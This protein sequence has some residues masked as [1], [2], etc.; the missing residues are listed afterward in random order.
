[1]QN[2]ALMI[3]QDL[4]KAMMERKKY[5][6][7]NHLS[8]LKAGLYSA[9]KDAIYSNLTTTDISFHLQ[10]YKQEGHEYHIAK[11]NE[12]IFNISF[13]IIENSKG[14]EDKIKLIVK[15]ILTILTLAIAIGCVGL[16]LSKLIISPIKIRMDKLNNFI[17][18]SAHELNTPISALMMSVSSIKSSGTISKK[19]LNHIS[20]STKLISEIYNTLSFHAFHERDAV[21]D[22]E[23]DISILIQESVSF[24]DEIAISKN[25]HFT[26]KLESTIIKMDKSRAKKITNNLLSNA[27][28]YGYK[29]SEISILLENRTLS[30]TNHGKGISSKNKDE[31]FQ[32]YKR[33]STEAGGFGIGLNI[34]KNI[35]D[36]YKIKIECHST[37]K[38]RTTFTLVFPTS[39][40]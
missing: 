38:E 37:P 10:S 15:I 4:M 26:C 6:F 22:E 11:L 21:L 28:K 40:S 33:A 7:K 19:T 36:Y 25:M 29:N 1:M 27:V 17:K 24:F 9:S 8:H 5:V 34:V 14:Y 35:C 39:L 12:P 18:D 3:K 20:I 31:I 30:V 2:E 16:Y 32:R 13:I 23:F